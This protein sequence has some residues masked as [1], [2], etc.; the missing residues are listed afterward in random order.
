[1]TQSINHHRL[2]ANPREQAF[3]D[4]WAAAN[5]DEG[6][7]S[8]I[9]DRTQENRGHYKPTPVEQETAATLIQWLGSPV[10]ESFVRNVLAEK[11]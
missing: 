6:L 7:L 4:A 2:S 1:M 10:G 5:Q 11:V 3:T 9:L 8:Y